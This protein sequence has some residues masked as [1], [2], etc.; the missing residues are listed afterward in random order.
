M[1]VLGPT[2]LVSIH[3]SQNIWTGYEIIQKMAVIAVIKI[4]DAFNHRNGYKAFV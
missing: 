2:I 3:A 1:D 4:N